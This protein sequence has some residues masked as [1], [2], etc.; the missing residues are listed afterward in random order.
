[1]DEKEGKLVVETDRT[2][3]PLWAKLDA[4]SKDKNGKEKSVLVEWHLR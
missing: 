4:N 1:M 3:K 2:G